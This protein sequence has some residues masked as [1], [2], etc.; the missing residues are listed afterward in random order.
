MSVLALESLHWPAIIG[1]M[2]HVWRSPLPSILILGSVGKI[3]R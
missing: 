2:A 3:G 1:H